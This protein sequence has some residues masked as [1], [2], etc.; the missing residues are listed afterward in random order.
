MGY[1]AGTF[2]WVGLATSDPDVAKTFYHGLFGWWPDDRVASGI[3]AFTTMR[4]GSKAVA[5]LYRQTPEARAASVPPHWTSF[6]SVDDTDRVAARVVELGGVVVRDSFRV[7]DLGRV[8]TAQD[9]TGAIVSFWEP[10]TESGA[11][12]H[13]VV[14]SFAWNELATRNPEDAANFYCELLGWRHASAGDIVVVENAGVVLG[15]IRDQNADEEGRPPNWIPC[16][17]ADDLDAL[18]RRAVLLGG[19]VLGPPT[20][21][22]QPFTSMTVR[23]QDPLGAHFAVSAG[24]VKTT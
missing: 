8:A 22:P 23:L 4:L 1:P 9:P 14:G 12:L 11:E 2:S 13:D 24:Q 15:V 17:A 18:A 16:F 5:L 3:G 10:G 21:A 7:D 19:R 6:I 20:A